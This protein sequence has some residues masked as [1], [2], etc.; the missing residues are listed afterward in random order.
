MTKIIHIITR[1][2]MG[3][4]AQNTLLT[5]RG[6]CDKYEIVLIHGLSL[7][8]NMTATEE[9]I[10][11][12]GIAAARKSGVRFISLASLVRRI[13]P[14]KDLWALLSLIWL[15][16]KENPFVVHTHSSKAG[17][18]GRLA[19]KVARVPIVIHTP[20]GHV[21]YGHFNRLSSKIFLWIEKC[22]ARLTDCII[23]LT[24]GE[25]EDYLE[26]SLGRPQNLLTV[27]SGVDI[28]RYMH[29]KI[30]VIEKKQALGLPSNGFIIGFVGWLL[31]VKGPMHLL[32][33]MPAVWR[34]LPEVTLVY[35]GKGDL[36]VDLRAAAVEFK[37]EDRVKFLGWRDDIEDLM[38]I[39][40][41]L[42][43]PS[44][45]EGMGRVVVEAMAAG[46]AVVASNVGGIPDLIKHNQT[47]LLVPP[48]DKNALAGAIA[49]L[50][51]NPEQ[52]EK[53]GSMGRY[54]SYSFSLAAMI[55]K[56]DAI[57]DELICSP[58]KVLKLKPQTPGYRDRVFSRLSAIND[59]R[60]H[61]P[62]RPIFPKKSGD[63]KK[64][65]RINPIR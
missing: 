20:H 8:S 31:P 32:Q 43:L 51:K 16:Y 54:H 23:A 33:A 40:D 13:S 59:S 63:E 11:H 3:G 6:L 22:F 1:L 36:D 47:G 38:H 64:S 10:V 45:N 49:H 21:F 30:D 42:V 4:S 50:V 61:L 39:F 55:D 53:M 29:H 18:L 5:G 65:N 9:H 62:E 52:A 35:V 41:V 2:D 34:E 60:K 17:I 37:A 26:L 15:L 56:L 24:Q 48:A 44:L 57:Y 14:L 19:A 27:H 12:K 28:S 7:E 58:Q 46:K 25:K